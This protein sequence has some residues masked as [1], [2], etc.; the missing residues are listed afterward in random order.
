MRKRENQNPRRS[1]NAP[2]PVLGLREWTLEFRKYL[3]KDLVCGLLLRR[4]VRLG[5]QESGLL[6]LLHGASGIQLRGSRSFKD[7][8]R[9]CRRQAR[10]VTCEAETLAHRIDQIIAYFLTYDR[11]GTFPLAGRF[12]AKVVATHAHFECLPELLSLYAR[13]LKYLAEHL[14]DVNSIDEK[15]PELMALWIYLQQSTNDATYE[16]LAQ[17]LECANASVEQEWDKGPEAV[18]K[19][20]ERYRKYHPRTCREIERLIAEYLEASKTDSTKAPDLAEY[21]RDGVLKPDLDAFWK[22][23]ALGRM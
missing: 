19:I 14:P 10:K 15:G 13:K 12:G 22:A 16:T 18:R 17:L 21:I 4:L 11:E 20:V 23:P 2:K 5:C 9:W 8:L 7:E 6:S 1:S 3:D